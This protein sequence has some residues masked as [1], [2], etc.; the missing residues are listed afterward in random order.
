MGD[1]DGASPLPQTPN[2]SDLT[3]SEHCRRM[4]AD[5]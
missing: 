4:K 5:G 3:C 1:E 2:S